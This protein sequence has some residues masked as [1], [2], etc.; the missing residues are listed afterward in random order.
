MHRPAAP[1]AAARGAALD[2]L[3][4]PFCELSLSMSLVTPGMIVRIACGRMMLREVRN[5]PM[6]SDAVAVD[7][8]RL[9][10]TMSPRII[11]AR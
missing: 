7:W 10:E 9:N 1:G 2:H 8:L 4:D 5:R 3:G 6:P 11:S